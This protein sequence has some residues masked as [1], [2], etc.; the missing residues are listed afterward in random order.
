MY[1]TSPILATPYCVTHALD[2]TNW[3]ASPVSLRSRFRGALMGLALVPIALQ[4]EA[5]LYHQKHPYQAHY[6]QTR[7]KTL[8]H[9]VAPGLLRY[10]HRRQHRQ[11]W[12]EQAIL[13]QSIFGEAAVQQLLWAG[14]WLETFMTSQKAQPAVKLS[15]AVVHKTIPLADSYTLSVQMSRQMMAQA[16]HP[17]NMPSDDESLILAPALTGFLAG[18]RVGI[19]S[20]PVLWQ[21]RLPQTTMGDT[22]KSTAHFSRQTI[23]NFADQ[24]YEQ[25]VG[26]L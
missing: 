24:L 22:A 17:L 13:S 5:K 7:W 3:P 20:L 26:I 10:H 18:A 23:L 25:W 19:A 6:H 8:M 15:A 11:Q 2:K 12:L 1:Q 14:D 16:G 4:I 9:T 21:M